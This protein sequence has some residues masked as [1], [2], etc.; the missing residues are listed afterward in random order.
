MA[1]D[2][3]AQ[4]SYG[5]TGNG[6]TDD[7][8]AIRSAMAYASA[9]G[10]GE[11]FLRNGTYLV[12]REG[13]SLSWCLA[14]PSNV[15]LRGESRA[16]VVLKMAPDQPA[17]TRLLSVIN[18]DDVEISRLTIDGNYEEQE[19][20]EEHCGG[21]FMQGARR[22]HIEDVTSS[23]NAGDGITVHADCADVTIQRVLCA[24][25]HRDGIAFT[26]GGQARI[27]LRDSQ[28][29]GNT[30]Q[31]FDVEPEGPLY[32]ITVDGCYFSRG[33]LTTGEAIGIEGD[34]GDELVCGIT[35]RSCRIEGPTIVRWAE[36]VR[37]HACRFEVS[38]DFNAPV[39]HINGKVIDSSFGDSTLV[40]RSTSYG[41]VVTVDG[42]SGA[43]DRPDGVLLAGNSIRGTLG[44]VGIQMAKPLAVDAAFNTI[45]GDDDATEAGIDVRTTDET[46]VR[47]VRLF[48]NRVVDYRRGYIANGNGAGPAIDMLVM[49]GNIAEAREHT[50]MTGYSPDADAAHAVQHAVFIGNETLNVNE[51]WNTFVQ[52]PVLVGGNRSGMGAMI[53]CKATPEADPGITPGIEEWTGAI[54]LRWEQTSGSK[55]Y[56]KESTGYG[57]TGWDAKD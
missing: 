29:I 19:E 8:A 5:A 25:N 4:S 2:Y 12:S 48:G 18:A 23:D 46:P 35:F 1:R 56:A 27:S 11:V 40:Q 45:I 44:H 13:E 26:G 49:L 28:F 38:A 14:I 22:L 20:P 33:A 37:F 9:A 10:G 34:S 55:L 3:D 7:S 21:I 39:L 16:G 47:C 24:D 43:D 51:P 41:A 17:F 36:S 50:N 31:D 6:T 57:D 54:A 30:N 42:R 32:D 53:A 52:C 15:T